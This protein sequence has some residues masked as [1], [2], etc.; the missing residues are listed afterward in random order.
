LNLASAREV[1]DES[2][3][4]SRSLHVTLDE[5]FG[6]IDRFDGDLQA[7]AFVDREGARRRADEL[8]AKR[9]RADELG[10]LFGV[11]LVVKSN[12]CVEGWETNC[13][14]RLL[15]GYRPPYNA[16]VIQR[17]LDADAVLIGCA[18]MDE[19]AM[20]SS[21]E[22]SAFASSKNPWDLQRAPGGSSS[23][24][25]A[26]VAAGYVPLALGSDTG[27]SVRQ[28]AALCGVS[29]F[30]PTYGR[31]SRFGLVAFGSSLDQVGPLARSA[32][33]LELALEVLQGS[34]GKD[35]RDATSIA[36][37]PAPPEN[38]SLR[39]LRI[40]MHRQAFSGAGV[41]RGVRDRVEEGF[42][43]L[44]AAG[45]ELVEFELQRSE[46]AIPTYYVIAT[47]EASSNLARFEGVRYGRRVEG[48]GS[49]AG[50]MASSRARGF[51]AEVKRRILLGTYVL[52]EGYREAWYE[53]A[54]ETR[55]AMGAEFA[56]AF[57]SLDLIVSPTS[58]TPAF[59]LGERTRDPLAMYASDVMTVP[60]SLAGLPAVSVPCG[61]VEEAGVRLPVGLQFTAA[62]G[63]DAFCLESAR[64]FEETGDAWQGPPTITSP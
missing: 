31:L 52:S 18:H 12:L 5:V 32:G 15:E 23:G 8:E 47:A 4:G 19:F 50:M 16:T 55:R 11:P 34:E 10:T 58:P 39:G 57:A 33:D 51:G 29:G 43:R 53:K 56:R 42:E 46:L 6:R 26:A 21:G 61:T 3:A 20:G 60:A 35:P 63:A 59:R 22:N 1:R 9:K 2:R 49:L 14:S 62:R 13:G 27:G 7:M 45:A 37:P 25:A 41:H 54:L 28:P 36:T 38:T 24:C 30:K 48:D 64:L 17:A 40:G 44:R